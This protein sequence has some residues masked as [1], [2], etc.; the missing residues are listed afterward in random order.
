MYISTRYSFSL[1]LFPFY[2]QIHQHSLTLQAM[3][4]CDTS[5]VT[6]LCAAMPGD[7]GNLSCQ[8]SSNPAGQLNIAAPNSSSGR[9]YPDG[10]QIIM[11]SSITIM[12]SGKYYCTATN[13]IS[14]THITFHLLVGS[15]FS[16]IGSFILRR[17]IER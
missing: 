3:N 14:S 6:I 12:D 10:N 13:R 5:S 15:K 17:F 2:F 11:F 8:F 16:I 4:L 9:L 1:I 7:Q